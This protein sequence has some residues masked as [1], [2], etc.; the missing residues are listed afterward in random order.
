MRSVA[1]EAAFVFVGGG[2][3]WLVDSDIV[4]AQSLTLAAIMD[5]AAPERRAK[6]DVGRCFYSMDD[7]FCWMH[8]EAFA[9]ERS[10]FADFD[11]L[12]I[13]R[14]WECANHFDVVALREECQRRLCSPVT[15]A[16][17]YGRWLTASGFDDNTEN[18]AALV[19]AIR[20]ECMRAV[21][22]AGPSIW[23][24]IVQ[25][26]E[27]EHDLLGEMLAETFRNENET[28]KASGKKAREEI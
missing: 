1:P 23:Y 6:L 9:H 16:D 7:M 13:S 4:R 21:R 20:R 26:H 19:G 8:N 15:G 27:V 2:S 22:I 11:D 5:A 3:E 17:I 14:L 18:G 10:S 24:E 25:A 28:E 12:D